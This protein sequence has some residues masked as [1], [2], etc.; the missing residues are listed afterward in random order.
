MRSYKN[1]LL[2]KIKKSIISIV[3]GLVSIILELSSMNREELIGQISESK[4]KKYKFTYHVVNVINTIV[5]F[6]I[7]Y[8]IMWIIWK[9]IMYPPFGKTKYTF[10][11]ESNFV[12]L[13]CFISVIGLYLFTRWI[14]AKE[15]PHIERFIRFLPIVP[16]CGV[17]SIYMADIG[18]T[19][20]LL[21]IFYLCV[22]RFICNS[23]SKAITPI[24]YPYPGT[25]KSQGLAMQ[26]MV[27]HTDKIK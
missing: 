22:L 24:V 15:Y 20:I 11:F 16:F 1:T 21:Q 2:C 8:M 25:S 19:D 4:R 17:I 27:K 26:H 10:P 7:N 6:A 23:L 12:I 18:K 13:T 14:W 9:I 5:L 3:I